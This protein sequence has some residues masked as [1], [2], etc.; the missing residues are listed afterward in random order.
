MAK[1]LK[2]IL[3]QE[4]PEVVTKAKAMASE[5][6]LNIHLAELPSEIRVH[7]KLRN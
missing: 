2:E 5:M 4:K 3:S 1:T 6:L 7:K